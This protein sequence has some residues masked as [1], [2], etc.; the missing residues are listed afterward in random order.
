M[1]NDAV[2]GAGDGDGEVEV[3]DDSETDWRFGN[4]DENA[5]EMLKKKKYAPK[6]AKKILYVLGLWKT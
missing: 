3:E 1:E 5:V 6:T 2:D 4:E